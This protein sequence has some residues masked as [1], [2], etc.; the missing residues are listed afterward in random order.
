MND[1]VGVLKARMWAIAGIVP[2]EEQKWSHI[3]EETEMSS[4]LKIN[5]NA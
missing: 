4:E 2:D 3:L 5:Q 1:S